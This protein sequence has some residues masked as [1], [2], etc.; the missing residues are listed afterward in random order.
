VPLASGLLTGKMTKST[1]FEKSDHRNFNR[2][3]AAFD[4][5]ETFAGV[6]FDKGL[7]AV[8]AL[9]SIKPE[10]STMAQFA[11]KWILM[12][13][14]VSCT[15]PGAKRPTQ[16]EDNCRASDLPDLSGKTMDEVRDIYEKFIKADVH[17]RW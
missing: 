15:I 13:D 8:E 9:E 17:Q 5:G 11:L 4:R 14:A 16:V 3:G 6:D 12:H 7:K 10:G 1:K 2:E